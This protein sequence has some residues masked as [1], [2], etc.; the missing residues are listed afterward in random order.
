MDIIVTPR[1]LPRTVR[2]PPSKSITHRALILAA[3]SPQPCRIRNPLLSGDGLTTLKAV[4]A[5]GA[6]ATRDGDDLRVHSEGLHGASVD[7]ENA[8]TALRLLM[9]VA[10]RCR[11][12][13]TFDGD[14]SLRDRPNGPLLH[15]LQAG[16][17]TVHGDRLPLTIQGPIKPGEYKIDGNA[18]SQFASSLMLTLPFLDAPS[19]L[20]VLGDASKPYL[21]VTT[22]VAS[23]LGIRTG[24]GAIPGGQTVNATGFTVEGDWSSAAF[25]LVAAAITGTTLTVEGLHPSSAQGDRRILQLLAAFGADVDGTTVRGGAL[26]SPGKVDVRHCPDLFPALC[27]LAA[28][29]QG[30]TRFT[31]GAAL[32]HKESDRIDAMAQGLAKLGITA[33]ASPGGLSVEGGTIRGGHADARGDHRIHMAF[34]IAGLI[35][36]GPVTVTHRESAAISYP[37]FHTLLEAP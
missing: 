28:A 29:S 12:K 9:G 20:T 34:A 22:S 32:R 10:A 35:A 36:E 2:V 33:R 5:M 8:G 19:T 7:C 25:P 23:A 14:A 1:A 37:G 21:D 4:Q 6:I 24:L 30:T 13:T 31:G 18:S 11:D 15:A 26:R 16:G 27:I 17:A 3:H